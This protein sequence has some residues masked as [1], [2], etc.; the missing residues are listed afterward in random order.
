LETKPSKCSTYMFQPFPSPCGEV[1]LETVRSA[2]FTQSRFQA[3]NRH[4][5]K[6]PNRAD[7]KLSHTHTSNPFSVK[8]R[9]TSTKNIG[10]GRFVEVCRWAEWKA[11]LMKFS[12]FYRFAYFKAYYNTSKGDY[13]F[14]LKRFSG[15]LLQHILRD[16]RSD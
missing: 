15:K 16:A 14:S 10:L 1:M 8:D 13:L 11:F 9:H 12:R 3:T 2:A 7:Q 4:T 6:K 5:S